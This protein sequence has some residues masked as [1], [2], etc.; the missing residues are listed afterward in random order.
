MMSYG[1]YVDETDRVDR[2]VPGVVR[3]SPAVAE[4]R[5]EGGV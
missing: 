2:D 4:V 5:E 3:G 1:L